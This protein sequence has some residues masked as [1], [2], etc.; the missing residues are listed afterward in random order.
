MKARLLQTCGQRHGNQMDLLHVQIR[1]LQTSR[2][3]ARTSSASLLA[4]LADGGGRASAWTENGGFP[5]LVAGPGLAR[6]L[7]RYRAAAAAHQQGASSAGTIVP[8]KA[9]VRALSASLVK[10]GSDPVPP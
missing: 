10:A 3:P 8:P 9:K 5:A 1:P 7:D 4:P 6:M 2:L